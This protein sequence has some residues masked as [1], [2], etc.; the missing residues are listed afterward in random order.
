MRP[1]ITKPTTPAHDAVTHS[2]SL[3]V[4]HPSNDAGR[5]AKRPRRT[6]RRTLRELNAWLHDNHDELL[7]IARQNCLRLTGQPTL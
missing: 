7:E 6:K 1:T 4:I 2:G 5:A 3:V